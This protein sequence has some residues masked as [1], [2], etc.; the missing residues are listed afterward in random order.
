MQPRAAAPELVQPRFPAADF[1]RVPYAVYVD[2]SIYAREQELIFR[3]PTWHYLGLEAEVPNS[4]SYLT[5]SI[6]DTPVV[7]TRNRAGELRAYVNRCTHRGATLCRH[8]RGQT[9]QFTCIYH[10][11]SFNL[12]GE[13]VGVPF[14][15]GIGGAGGMRP[16]FDSGAHGLEPVRVDGYR[17]LVFGT[18]ND[19]AAALPEYLGPAML[20]LLD[21]T[22]TGPL[23][24]LG[25]QKQVI[26]AN[27]KLY[28]ENT[29]DPYH[30]SLLHLF[31]T[32]FGLYRATLK[33]GVELSDSG[34]NSALYSIRGTDT[35]AAVR[36]AYEGTKFA[37]VRT[38]SSVL[39]L[40]D[41]SLLAGRDEFG[42]GFTNLIMYLF[43]SVV[44]QQIANTLATRKVIPRGPNEFE[45]YWT[46]LGFADDD[47]ATRG[48]RIKQ[49]NLIG[50]AG[51]ISMED[52]EATRLV[53]ESVRTARERHS[54]VEL[55]AA[56]AIEPQHHLVTETS[57]RA[58]WSGYCRL[59]GYAVG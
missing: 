52:G 17:G 45:L 56:E 36:S 41:P 10:Q 21:R 57:I 46:Y 8:R 3:G 43:P 34:L 39:T 47:A 54:V 25:Y 12:E 30:A 26:P 20:R 7:L 6:G 51:F 31:H 38:D 28:A 33:G 13:L 14:R 22:L 16:E 9:R 2:P 58:M 40:S 50:P 11:W 48:Y 59:M 55:G 15:K 27:W 24:V 18:L 4:G 29:K 35:N 32:T 42:D 1:S 37:A 44:L 23:A 5:T 49:A 53:Q 19:A